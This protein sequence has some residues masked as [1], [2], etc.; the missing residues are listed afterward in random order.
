[1][2]DWTEKRSVRD[3]MVI[4]IK[5]TASYHAHQREKELMHIILQETQ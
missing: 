3:R 4:A 5:Y 1:M 2:G